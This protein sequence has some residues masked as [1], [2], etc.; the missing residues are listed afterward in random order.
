LGLGLTSSPDI[1]REKYKKLAL[2]YHPDRK[3]GDATKFIEIKENYE[4]IISFL[5][6]D[7][8][9]DYI[10]DELLSLAKN[11]KKLKEKNERKKNKEKKKEKRKRKEKEKKKKEEEIETN[12]YKNIYIILDRGIKTFS[13]KTYCYDI[14]KKIIG[15]KRVL[16]DIYDK[17]ENPIIYK[18]IGDIYLRE[19]KE[20]IEEEEKEEKEKEKEKEKE[21]KEKEEEEE[22]K[23]EK[24]KEEEE[25][26]EEEKEEKEEKTE[27]NAKSKEQEK[28]EK[29]KEEEITP[30]ITDI[31]V[32][33]V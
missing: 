2:I 33:I 21:E 29:T 20:K 22:E 32:R 11:H 8:K 1:I 25:K 12:A 18:G 14:D 9:E 13:L 24:E 27:E 3:K 31:I 19:K 30:I 6:E 16:I 15:C 26:E 23:E 28:K 5:E 17:S 7:G 10:D 4:R